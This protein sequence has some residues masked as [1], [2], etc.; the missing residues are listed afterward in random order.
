[1]AAE[2]NV[3]APII[4]PYG[5]G[6]H[7]LSSAPNIPSANVENIIGTL[8]EPFEFRELEALLQQVLVNQGA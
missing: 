7:N 5:Y 1:L 4:M 8:T 3:F 6:K 2:P